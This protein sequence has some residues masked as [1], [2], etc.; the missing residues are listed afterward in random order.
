MQMYVKCSESGANSEVV[1][2]GQYQ[3]YI[4]RYIVAQFILTL[5]NVWYAEPGANSPHVPDLSTDPNKI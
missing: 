4:G 3:L 1:I 5:R 2:N